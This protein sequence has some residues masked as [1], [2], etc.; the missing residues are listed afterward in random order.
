M[1]EAGRAGAIDE[2]LDAAEDRALGGG[3]DR[4]FPDIGFPTV[5]VLRGSLSTMPCGSP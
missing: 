3:R 5:Y 1:S 2:R 4:R